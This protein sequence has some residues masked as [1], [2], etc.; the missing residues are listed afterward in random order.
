MGNYFKV[1]R[2]ITSHGF[3]KW[4]WSLH[5]SSGHMYHISQG[6]ESYT[7]CINDLNALGELWLKDIS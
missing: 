6:F 1:Q 5:K 3:H 4:Y 2:S 7:E